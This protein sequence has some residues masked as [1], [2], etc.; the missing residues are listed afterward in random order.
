ME[1]LFIFTF[2]VILAV[3][4]GL[5]LGA[6]VAFFSKENKAKNFRVAFSYTAIF[7]LAILTIMTFING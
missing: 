6:L 3:T 7:V 2:S 5:F 1:Y 4:A